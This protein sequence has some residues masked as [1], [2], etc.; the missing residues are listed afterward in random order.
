MTQYQELE[1]QLSD[2]DAA[3]R[4]AALVQLTRSVAAADAPP[5]REV[6]NM[7]SHS[8][9][10]FNAF[11]FSP[12][13]IAWLAK[14]SGYGLMGI[15]D[16]DVL[17]G[18]E[19]FLSACEL[20]GVRGSVGVETRV[21]IPEFGAY[22][23]NSVGEPGV[24]YVM[25]IGFP[26]GETPA[27]AADLLSDM[28]QRA[29]RRNQT[30]LSTLNAYLAPVNISYEGD[31]LPLTPGGYATERHIVLAYV[32]AA[33]RTVSDLTAYWA[34]KLS[35]QTAQATTLLADPAVLQNTIRV[36]LMKRGGVGYVKPNLTSFPT[37][38]EFQAFVK[39]CGA[40]PCATWLD[41]TSD[42]E[43]RIEDLLTLLISKGVRALNIIPDR[44]WNNSDPEMHR[45][46]VQ[47]LYDVV[48]LAAKLDLPLVVGTE[49]NS[50]GQRLIDDFDAPHLAPVRDAFLD[51]A[52]FIYGH[53][54]AQRTLG[55]GHQSEWAQAQFHSRSQL[56]AFYTKLGRA[57]P[58]TATT[59]QQ[60]IALKST[61]S[62]M[63]P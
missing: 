19:E 43:A 23:I 35:M 3:K 52:Y 39:A 10:S 21:Y 58:N 41:G 45:R 48:A 57:M 38:E 50:F 8:F 11:G 60:L 49:M 28:R 9:F 14:T 61:I 37:L 40:L 62:S 6:A 54:L 59:Q 51:G 15:V 18:A 34:E 30:M 24:Y 4:R 25:G 2:F 36:R 53:T 22:E 13:R 44:N 42:G 46:K 29:T 31:V 17:D 56:N 7:H 12:S 5:C 1:A 20:L 27:R 63:T 47:H 26:G 33:E 16:F 55:I 32:R